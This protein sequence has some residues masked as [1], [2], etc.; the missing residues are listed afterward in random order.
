[1]NWRLYHKE[2]TL[3]TNLDARQGRP[4]D[5]FT[6]DEQ[7]AGR[8]RLDHPWHSGKGENLALSAVLDVTDLPAEHVAT[9]PLMVGLGVAQAVER[10]LGGRRTGIKWP[11]DVLVAGRKIAGILCERHGERVIAG[12]GVNVKTRRFP[13]DFAARATSFALEGAANVPVAAV[14]EA[15][16]AELA[17][18]YPVWRG[19]GLSAFYAQIAERDVLKGK[20]VEVSQSAGDAQRVR[21]IC[22]GIAPTGV[23]R[24]GDEPVYAG[25]AHILAIS[26]LA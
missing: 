1:M 17:R 7:T 25:E 4:G 16:L 13:S 5:V 3:S 22:G 24:V 26:D 21:G 15:V 20:I 9:L 8:G 2:S 19:Q 12:L 10:L 23:L 14:R 11:N 18:L 6:A